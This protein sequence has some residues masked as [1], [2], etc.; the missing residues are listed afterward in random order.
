MG[1]V[2]RLSQH[3]GHF[4]HCHHCSPA[5]AGAN[6]RR[7]SRHIR[8]ETAGEGGGRG[9]VRRHPCSR[10]A[11]PGRRRKLG[12]LRGEIQ[13]HRG[14]ARRPRVHFRLEGAR[15]QHRVVVVSWVKQDVFWHTS[16][17][18]PRTE[19]PASET[20]GGYPMLFQTLFQR[21]VSE[22]TQGRC[23]RGLFQRSAPGVCFR[24]RN[25]NL[26]QRS[27]SEVV[28]QVCFRL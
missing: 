27:V 24:F 10:G 3:A 11:D 5:T 2:G 12:K 1:R 4:H 18:W 15:C 22:V 26:F 9:E 17:M 25:L 6:G 7:R 28:S 13:G 16:D 19:I 14:R 20:A 23:F 8:E 21:C